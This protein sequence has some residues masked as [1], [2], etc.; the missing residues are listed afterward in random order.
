MCIV[1]KR[2]DTNETSTCIITNG[3]KVNQIL[4]YDFWIEA[5]YGPLK[6]SQGFE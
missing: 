5:L 4:P 2:Y 1:L 6:E 3:I